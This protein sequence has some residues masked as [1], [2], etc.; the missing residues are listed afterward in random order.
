MLLFRQLP[1]SQL[2]VR[3][4]KSVCLVFAMSPSVKSP[5]NVP[6]GAWYR[7][8]SQTKT[9]VYLFPNS[10]IICTGYSYSNF[11]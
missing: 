7:K 4:T 1:T 5:G 6:D 2:S 9:V 3:R 11:L 8:S 10:E